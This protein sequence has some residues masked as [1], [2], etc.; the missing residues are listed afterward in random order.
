MNLTDF[1]YE[2]LFNI[3]LNAEPKDIASYCQTS[4]RASRICRDQDFWRAKLWTDYGQEEQIE[5]ITWKRQ[6]Q[7]KRIKVINSPMA[8]GNSYLGVIDNLGDLYITGLNRTVGRL[9]SR[10]LTKVDLE[11]KVV[12]VIAG[13]GDDKDSAFI[14]VV[15]VDGEAYT[16]NLFHLVMPRKPHKLNF[17]QPGKIVKMVRENIY[18]TYGIIM[19]NGRAYLFKPHIFPA[20]VLILPYSGRKVVDLII[21]YLPHDIFVCY[22]LDNYGDVFFFYVTDNG[23]GKTIKLDFPDPI[24][25]LSASKSINAALSINGD[26]YTWS[27]THK[28]N[29]VNYY[30]RRA[31]EL[32]FEIKPENNSS[33]I[34]KKIYKVNLPVLIES[35]STGYGNIAAVTNKGTVYVWGSN[36]HNRLVD[37][38]EEVKLLAS[39]QMVVFSGR[40]RY[41]VRVII[42]PLELKLES[43]IKFIS[44]GNMFTIALTEDGIINYWGPSYT[45][46]KNSL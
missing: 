4:E 39:G 9:A 6:Y 37:K 36:I 46:I 30:L 3:L 33:P 16:W 31:G 34:A 27:Y 22:F 29:D 45:F 20:H 14:G 2:V 44:L 28:N 23:Q 41:K 19:D 42:R 35:I 26:V 10:G 40:G 15:T 17:S 5:R 38:I 8:A 13:Y 43:K 32:I 25:Q 11:P 18:K 12:S 21:P 24:R 7:L 1:P